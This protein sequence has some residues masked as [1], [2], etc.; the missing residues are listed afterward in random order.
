MNKTTEDTPPKKNK[1]FKKRPGYVE[2]NYFSETDDD[3]L[4]KTC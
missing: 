2:V 3:S 1:K 4:G